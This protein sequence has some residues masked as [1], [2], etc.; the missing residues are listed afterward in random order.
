MSSKFTTS[1][2]LGFI[3]LP[4]LGL[5]LL[6][7]QR[8]SIGI[9]KSVLIYTGAVYLVLVS[10]LFPNWYVGIAVAHISF[11]STILWYS[12]MAS[13][14]R[15][16]KRTDA[17]D[18][19][20]MISILSAIIIPV[21]VFQIV[22]S[23]SRIFGNVSMEPCTNLM[24]SWFAA[25]I[26]L[27]LVLLLGRQCYWRGLN[28][29]EDSLD[30]KVTEEATLFYMVAGFIAALIYPFFLSGFPNPIRILFCMFQ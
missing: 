30:K 9:W 28:W 25:T 26:L 8:E 14:A 1:S 2:L 11:L 10:R 20:F 29:F 27:S 19:F 13:E 3:A 22:A 15:H 21:C 5:F 12:I 17:I 6:L 7:R 18:G 23:G 4:V 16:Y 24:R